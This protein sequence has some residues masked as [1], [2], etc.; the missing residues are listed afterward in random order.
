MAW[1]NEASTTIQKN[2]VD[3]S[4]SDDM[5]IRHSYFLFSTIQNFPTK[6]IPGF[7]YLCWEVGTDVYVRIL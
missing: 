6:I 5:I 1:K 3:E 2:L 7:R 4:E